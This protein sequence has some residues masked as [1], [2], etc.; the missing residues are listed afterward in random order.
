VLGFLLL[1]FSRRPPRT[2]ESFDSAYHR[3]EEGDLT[4]EEFERLRHEGLAPQPRTRA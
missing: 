3:F 2:T 1:I 4:P